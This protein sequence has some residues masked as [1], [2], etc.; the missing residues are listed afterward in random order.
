[1]NQPPLLVT[2]GL[3]YTNGP[4]HLGHLRTYVPADAY[5]RY[6]R[7]MGGEVVFVCGSDNHGTPIVVSA[8]AEGITPRQ[9]SEKYHAHFDTTFRR[10][11]VVFDHFGMTDD[12][13][14]HARTTAIVQALIDKGHVYAQVVRQAYCVKCKRFLPDR[15]VE[16]ICP[17]C[18]A[19]ARGDECDQGCGKHLEPGEIKEPVCKV[20]GTKA[21]FRNQEHF[22][23]R[24][25]AFRDYLLP[26]LDTVRGTSNAKNYA[27]GW[28][29]EELHD[30]CITRTLEWGVKFP[31]RN[32]LVVYVWVDAPIGY[33]AFTEEWANKAGKDWQRYWGAEN[34]VTH[35]IGGDIIYHHCIF[36]PALLRGAGYGVP[37]AIV[38][39]GML[40][41]DDHKFSKSRGYV[42]WTNE[43]YLDKGLPADYLRYYLLAYTSHTKELNFSWKLFA[44]RINNEVVNI[45]GNF[46]NRTLQFAHREF[47][48]VPEGAADP[49]ITAEIE[50]TLAVVNGFMQE[51]EFKGAVDAIMALAA[52]GNTYV[53]GS[54]PWK[55][56]KTDRA[57]A[58]QVIRNCAQIA[59]ALALLIEPVMPAKAQDCWALLG[60]TDAVAAHPIAEAVRPVPARAIMA[61]KP[62][63]AR[64]EENQVKDLDALLQQ[65]VRAAD[66]KSEKIPVVSF[67][68]F[69][70]LDIRTGKVLSCEP[71]PKSNKLLKLVVDIGTEKR[72]I[73]A[74]MQQFYKPDEMVG[75]DV[76][77]VTNLAP[78]KIF[79]VESNGMILAAGDAAS[80]LVP[81]RPVEP[82]SKVR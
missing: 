82:G 8:E 51:Y 33:I 55:L 13:T 72:Q 50:K 76:I 37:H 20:C 22:F 23:F 32:D 40:K 24:L 41:V 4:C 69:Q 6:M 28:I 43:D 5:V 71:V 62:L 10:M 42:V 14:N 36:W 53:Q 1:M 3:P 59:Q 75:K 67:E 31:G 11:G 48:G 19:S 26:Y 68:E 30:W 17:H 65:R 34:R 9:M 39:S 49:A 45:F 44:E 29:N 66:R 25:S 52:Y 78:A 7:R 73:V 74:G 16:G 18:G 54:A 38:A 12:P 47:G 64:M 60:Y 27:I 70:K 56:V 58:A 77:V 35:F 80:L 63:F 61:P 46:V 81:L 21:E 57:A 15:Y 79:G 2:C